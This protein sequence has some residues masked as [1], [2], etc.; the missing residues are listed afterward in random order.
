MTEWLFFEKKKRRKELIE[1]REKIWKEE[2][3]KN[4]SEF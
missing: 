4:D 1:G 3:K 2:N